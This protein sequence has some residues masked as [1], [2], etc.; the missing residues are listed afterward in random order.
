MTDRPAWLSE[1][2]FPFQSRYL[3]I[4]GHR[5]HYVDEGEGPV[6]LML[7]GNP[8]WSFLYRRLI[9]DLS[10]SFRCIALDYPGF[11]LSTAADGYG[12]TAAEH[13]GVVSRFVA[14]LGLDGIT[15]IS[16]DW[17]GPI[18][19]GAAQGDPGQYR[20]FII[21]N[22]WS[23]PVTDQRRVRQFSATLGEGRSG[24]MLSQRLNVFVK[25]FM[26]RGMRRRQPTSEEMAMWRGP[27]PTIESRYP[28]MV[29]PREIIAATSFLAELEE[30]LAAV[31]DRPALLFHA[32]KDLAFGYRD[33]ARWQSIFG[34]HHAH[35]LEGAGHYWQDDAGPEAAL[36]IRRWWADR[37]E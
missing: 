37:M 26:K 28:V 17:G 6:L 30:G 14:E 35:V 9:G 31:A 16:Q 22:T 2:L 32:D 1:D 23:W 8:T 15:T 13:S 27:F 18:G 7:H 33:F 4:E 12:F 21:G 25:V 19:M 10:D 11:G 34:D 24:E 3:D 29:F 5:V 36:V 20:A